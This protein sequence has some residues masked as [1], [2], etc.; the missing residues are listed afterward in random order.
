MEIY[1]IEDASLFPNSG[2][3]ERRKRILV[4]TAVDAEKDAICRGLKGDGRFDVLAAGVGP[5]AAAVGTAAVL[6]SAKSD[7]DLVIS[8]GIGGGFPGRAPIGSLVVA[9][10]MVAADLGA[11]TPE[12][13]VSLDKLGFGTAR[14]HAHGSLVE[15]VTEALRN[16]GLP[17]HTGPVLTVSTVTGTA[18]TAAAL[19][20]RIPGAAAEGME[21]YGVAAAAVKFGIPVLEIRAISNPVGPRDRD[22]WRIG[23]ALNALEAASTILREVQL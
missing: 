1:H 8:A 10:E 9:E 11:E 18:A 16:A 3:E 22:A 15:R 5:I 13:F 20:A 23:D 6:A 7:Y 19:S 12:G 2:P 17:V 14:V 4:I 21:G